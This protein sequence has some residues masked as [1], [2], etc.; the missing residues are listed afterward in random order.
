MF[1]WCY[2]YKLL[3]EFMDYLKYLIEDTK[4]NKKYETLDDLIADDDILELIDNEDW[5]ELNRIIPKE[6]I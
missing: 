5:E 3:G 6:L 4:I 2:N 1:G